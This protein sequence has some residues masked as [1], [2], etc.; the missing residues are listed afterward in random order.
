MDSALQRQPSVSYGGHTCATR[1]TRPARRQAPAAG[2]VRRR[3]LGSRTAACKLLRE[4][5]ITG[6]RTNYPV[7]GYKVDVAFPAAK[8]AVE[9]DG[10]A[11]H[12]DQEDFQNDR[13]R[14]NNMPCSVGKLLHLARPAEY[15]QRVI[16]E[17][18]FATGQ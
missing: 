4:A 14:Q 15:P 12:S 9:T 6:W 2:R 5:G 13:N 1:A 3:T 8:V 7:G 17:V 10:W 16:A 18:K 11:F